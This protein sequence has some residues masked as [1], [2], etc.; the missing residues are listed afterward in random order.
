MLRSTLESLT[1]TTQPGGEFQDDG[2]KRWWMISFCPEQSCTPRVQ[3]DGQGYRFSSFLLLSN[4]RMSHTICTCFRFESLLMNIF[5]L[6]R[7]F[8]FWRNRVA[9]CTPSH[10]GMLW[11]TLMHKIWSHSLLYIWHY[12]AKSK[13]RLYYP[14]LLPVLLLLFFNPH[15][16]NTQNQPC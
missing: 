15:K 1:L 3:H 12:K 11:N 7:N 13:R 16:Q 6:I 5:T 9:E 2:G 14:P 4:P 8:G 10:R